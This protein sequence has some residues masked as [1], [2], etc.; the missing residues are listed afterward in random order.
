M[1]GANG[2]SEDLSNWRVTR[3]DGQRNPAAVGVFQTEIHGGVD[4]VERAV[5]F[6]NKIIRYLAVLRSLYD[7]DQAIRLIGTHPDAAYSLLVFA[8]E[9][10]AQECGDFKSEWEDFPLE[11]DNGDVFETKKEHDLRPVPMVQQRTS[12][13][14]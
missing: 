14:E 5:D 10:L 8:L 7:Y 13:V 3:R 2:A 6:I 11:A 1:E 12:S 4:D 9:A